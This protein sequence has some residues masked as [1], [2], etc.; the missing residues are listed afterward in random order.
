MTAAHIF[1]DISYEDDD[2]IEVKYYSLYHE[3]RERERGRGRE[4]GRG[5][6]RKGSEI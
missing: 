4:G 2:V 6:E 3:S 1:G 5:R